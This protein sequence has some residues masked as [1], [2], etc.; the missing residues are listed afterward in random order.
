MPKHPPGPSKQCFL[1]SP[2]GIFIYL[3]TDPCSGGKSREKRSGGFLLRGV[4]HSC[5]GLRPVCNFSRRDSSARVWRRLELPG[6]AGRG[7]S[8]GGRKT[9]CASDRAGIGWD[10]ARR[11]PAIPS[12]A[13]TAPAPARSPVS[14][15]LFI[16]LFSFFISVYLFLF[17]FLFTSVCLFPFIFLLIY[18]YL[19]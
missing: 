18:V 15:S 5:S 10:G 2:L 11:V 6:L 12:T 19:C 7:E 3:P 17:V 4:R 8:R 14:S 16:S 9:P 1:A 13:G